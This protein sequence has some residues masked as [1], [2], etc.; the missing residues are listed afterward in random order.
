MITYFDNPEEN[1]RPMRIGCFA[2]NSEQLNWFARSFC[3]ANS[4]IVEKMNLQTG[5]RKDVVLKDETIMQFIPMNN[6][7]RGYKFDQVL[8]YN[9]LPNQLPNHLV[10]LDE[11]YLPE[12]YQRFQFLEYDDED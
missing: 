8:L 10:L 9:M 11:S 4:D 7:L 1:Y 6:N 3:D 2:P 5:Y 12:E